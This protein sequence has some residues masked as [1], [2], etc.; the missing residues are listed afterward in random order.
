MGLAQPTIGS[1]P[2]VTAVRWLAV[3]LV[4]LLAATAAAA[5]A[6]PDRGGAPTT[7]EAKALSWAEVAALIGGTAQGAVGPLPAAVVDRHRAKASHW[8]SVW[9]QRFGTPMQSW[10]AAELGK[11]AADVVFYPFS[12]PDFV[13]LH[14]MMP[15]ARHYVM[16]AGQVAGK[17]PD[18]AHVPA[19][20][21][22][23]WLH[24][25]QIE[26]SRFAVNGF[27][28]TREL[29]DTEQASDG[30]QGMISILL[31][32]TSREG[33]DVLD[34]APIRLDPST[35]QWAPDSQP[36]ARWHA[37]RMTLRRQS[38]GGNVLLDYISV[39]LDDQHLRKAAPLRAWVQS[40]ARHPT[41]IKAASHQLQTG[42]YEEVAT[43]LLDHAPLLLQD[44]SGV[45]FAR[46][47]QRFAV[48]LYGKYSGPNVL[49]PQH[50]QHALRAAYA[51]PGAARPLAMQ[52]GYHK[53]SGSCW[54]VARRLAP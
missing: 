46:V 30:L 39:N 8:W 1:T 27:F 49:F 14:R 31:Y 53:R 41:L 20:R 21:T 32:F 13:T 11:V 37:I 4:M 24:A 52:I 51:R 33:F 3:V 43:A 29:N 10:R 34:I 38:D 7:G 6:G 18:L 15:M 12:G 40:M 16:V 28:R 54:M 44:E 48:Q 22:A 47:S 23:R 42:G 9:E 5:P 2:R 17:L 45:A 50:R 35:L 26:M 36:Q 19:A 25:L